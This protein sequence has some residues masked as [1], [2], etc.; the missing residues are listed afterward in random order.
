MRL[1]LFLSIFQ[2]KYRCKSYLSK[3]R[4]IRPRQKQINI[5]HINVTENPNGTEFIVDFFTSNIAKK[6][7]K[8]ARTRTG[9]GRL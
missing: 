3:N 6:K 9:N 7:K 4:R 8:T 2:Q 1:T 5:A